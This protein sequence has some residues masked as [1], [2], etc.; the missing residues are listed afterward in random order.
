MRLFDFFDE[1]RVSTAACW[2]CV[3]CHE[4]SDSDKYVA[5]L[6]S[7]VFSAHEQLDSLNASGESTESTRISHCWTADLVV[8]YMIR[9]F[10]QNP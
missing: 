4:H 5:T 8:I 1:S 2:N 3:H 6:Y 7:N 10:R 9:V